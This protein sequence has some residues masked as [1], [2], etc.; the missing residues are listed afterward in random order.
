MSQPTRSV[1]SGS[2]PSALPYNSESESDDEFVDRPQTPQIRPQANP[3]TPNRTTR[4]AA[5]M[6]Q[7]QQA[8]RRESMPPLTLDPL[9]RPIIRR[10]LGVHLF[11]NLSDGFSFSDEIYTVMNDINRSIEEINLHHPA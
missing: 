1:S 11:Q 5:R 7:V 10:D 2:L 4:N 9:V 6:H 3:T 8:P